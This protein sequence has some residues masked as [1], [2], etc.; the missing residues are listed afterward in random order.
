MIY[1]A[2]TAFAVTIVFVP[3]IRWFCQ[4]TH[5]LDRPGPL[6]IHT[7]AV[8][9]LGGVAVFL[10]IV[11]GMFVS[12]SHDL[13]STRY[14]F[15]SL[16]LVWIIGLIDD[17]VGV[18]PAFRLVV[19]IAAAALLWRGGWQLSFGQLKAVGFLAVCLLVVLFVNAFNFLDGSDGMAAGV[20]CATAIAY[21]ALPA[22]ALEP[23]AAKIA[24]STAAACAAFLFYNSHPASIFLGD[25][26]SNLLGFLAAFWALGLAKTSG[27][28][29]H[30]LLFPFVVAALP[31]FDA[32]RIIVHR[33]AHRRSAFTG[34]RS[35]FYDLHASM[36]RKPV[37]IAFISTCVAAVCGAIG[38]L[39]FRKTIS[40]GWSLIA[41]GLAALW[42][43]AGVGSFDSIVRN[44][45]K[46]EMP[47]SL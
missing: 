11:T 8:P 5:I 27:I 40:S 15:S 13:I 16:A 19:Q 30:T 18:R 35:H 4:R 9:R 44:N 25:S 36:G 42:I 1:A 22:S 38:V 41:F 6:T 14:F 45:E 28:S 29:S 24:C 7:R 3:L 46:S 43:A 39:I 31:L 34:D 23:L 17:L 10:A 47:A 21:V 33:L 37:T 26:G 20:A 2:F 32:V 12:R